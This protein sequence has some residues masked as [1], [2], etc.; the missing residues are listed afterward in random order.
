VL[1]EGPAGIGKTRLVE[2]ARE[3]GREAG[4][5]VLGARGTELEAGV[6]FGVVRQLLDP[7]V[8][9]GDDAPALEGAAARAASVFHGD[10]AGAGAAGDDTFTKLHGLFWLLSDLAERRPLL[11]L[12]DD[13][14][15]ADPPSLQLLAFLAP[16]LDD[17]AATLVVATRPVAEAGEPLLARLRTDPRARVLSPTPLSREAIAAAAAAALGAEPDPAFADACHEATGGNPFFVVELLREARLRGLEPDSAGAAAVGGLAPGG[18]AAM[19]MLR[20]AD[21]PAGAQALAEAAAVLGERATLGDAAT[22]AELDQAS[23]RAAAD[24]LVAAGILTESDR[25]GFAHPVVRRAVEAGVPRTRWA[26]AHA[27]AAELLGAAGAPAE[28]VA[29]HLLVAPPAG[30]AARVATLREAAAGALARGA[31]ASALAPLERALAEPPDP[32]Q[33]PALLRELGAAAARAGSPDAAGYLRRAVEAAGDP[34]TRARAAIE[35]ARAVKYGGGAAEAL[36]LLDRALADTD[37][38]ALAEVLEAELLSLACASASARRTLRERIDAVGEPAP[39]AVGPGAAHAW[40]SLAF[41]AGSSGRS[42]AE[43]AAYA[44][45][46]PAALGGAAGEGDDWVAL[47]TTAAAVFAEEFD[48][49]QRVTDQLVSASQAAGAALPLSAAVSL[50]G[51]L[52]QR[53]GRLREAE[54]DAA[55][56]LR[57]AEEAYGTDVLVTVAPTTLALVAADQEPDPEVLRGHL[58]RLAGDDTDFLPFVEVPVAR[59]V[60]L[61]ALGEPEAALTELREAERLAW[62]DGPTVAPWR[63]P[64]ALAL[65]RL[66][67]ADEAVALAREEAELCR[68][69]GVRRALAAA[70]RTEAVVSGQRSPDALAEAAA[71]LEDGPDP[72]ELARTLVELGAALRAARRPTEARDPLRRA[73]EL[74]LRCGAYGLAARAREELLASG[75]RPRRVALQGVDALTPSERRVAELA[76]GGRTNREIAQELY[77]TQKTVEGHLRHAYDKLGVR[78]R[79]ELGDALRA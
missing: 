49:A 45:R 2:A 19:V 23:A 22:L 63:C 29:Q 8:L 61:L 31:P 33:E 4:F 36:P 6:P 40:A 56:A 64:A 38:P 72:L 9:G 7:V 71:L 16:R 15:W 11:L 5:R 28:D 78:S 46:V 48:L 50:R 18:V 70:L 20:L 35:L 13:A 68:R 66:G 75:A 67:R 21:A 79:L 39:D 47:M 26:A 43:A 3:H 12:V 62:A 10:P 60:L 52:N 30:D 69:L 1:I 73:T 42:A 14:Q 53:R 57:L 17:L 41:E 37:D 51:W 76:A 32:A 34:P 59:G 25:L 24:A 44:A 55:F 74:A 65:S 54:T 77:V 27:R 58:Q